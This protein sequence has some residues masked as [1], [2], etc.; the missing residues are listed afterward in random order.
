MV[1]LRS[2]RLLIGW[3]SKVPNHYKVN[4]GDY[5]I[6][7][8]FLKV[9]QADYSLLCVGSIIRKFQSTIDVE[10]SFITPPIF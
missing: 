9:L 1:N 7:K 4:D 8:K 3:S 2:T 10:D 6:S 5:I